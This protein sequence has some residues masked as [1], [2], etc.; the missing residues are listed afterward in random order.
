MAEV[1]AEAEA[2]A[3]RDGPPIELRVGAAIASKLYFHK[4]Y[5]IQLRVRIRRHTNTAT[6][7]QAQ[8]NCHAKPTIMEFFL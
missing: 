2:E 6:P 3:N 4:I 1:E 7:I 8:S 5:S